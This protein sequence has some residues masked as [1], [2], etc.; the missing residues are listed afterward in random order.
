LHPKKFQE[1]L[2][3]FLTKA[4]PLPSKSQFPLRQLCVRS[5]LDRRISKDPQGVPSDNLLAFRRQWID[6]IT[7]C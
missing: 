6:L 5:M 7:F 1:Q 3:I 2:Q 4:I